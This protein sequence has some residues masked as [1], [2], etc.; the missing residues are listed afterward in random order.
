MEI[1]EVR[2]SRDGFL[3]IPN[4]LFDYALKTLKPSSLFVY[5]ALARMANNVTQQCFPSYERLAD[6]T[7][8]SRATV[9]TALKDLRTHRIITW[10]NRDGH[11]VY[12]LLDTDSLKIGRVQSGEHDSPISEAQQSSP[13]DPNKTHN[14]TQEQYFSSPPVQSGD[15]LVLKSNEGT[16]DRPKKKQTPPRGDPRHSPFLKKLNDCWVYLNPEVPKFSWSGGE[17]GQLA[18]FLRKWPKLTI[19]EFHDWLMAYCDSD[20]IVPSKTPMQFLPFI[21]E[22]ATGPRDKFHHLLRDDRAQA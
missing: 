15:D 19:E 5:L 18:I 6:M 1:F 12:S 2:D 13:L 9:A 7:G 11:N 10:G 17:V 4:S 16:L 14:K 21:H 20:D 22:Y 3:W 8:L